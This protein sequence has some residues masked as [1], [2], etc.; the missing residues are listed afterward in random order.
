MGEVA[1]CQDFC[2]H[3]AQNLDHICK[4]DGVTMASAGRFCDLCN[5][6]RASLT[7]PA[8]RYL[9]PRYRVILPGILAT[10]ASEPM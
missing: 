8:A 5:N 7:H 9:L 3:Y 2:A 6:L 4:K 1:R 10:L